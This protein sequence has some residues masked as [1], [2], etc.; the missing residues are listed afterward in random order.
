VLPS[1]S[2]SAGSMNY[3]DLGGEL[4]FGEWNFTKPLYIRAVEFEFVNDR[5]RHFQQGLTIDP[6]S[7]ATPRVA[8]MGGFNYAAEYGADIIMNH[9]PD[10][11]GLALHIAPRIHGN[12]TV[13][14]V[15]GVA[16]W[17]EVGISS[18]GTYRLKACSQDNICAVSNVIRTF[19][20]DDV[21]NNTILSQPSINAVASVSSGD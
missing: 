11:S 1:P 4:M 10:S 21:W 5:T 8:W 18:L 16:S 9:E 17:A 6:T 19:P 20:P 7:H 14:S 12:L 13:T 15:R 3:T 2:A